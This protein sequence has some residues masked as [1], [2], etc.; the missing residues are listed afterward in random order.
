MNVSFILCSPFV[1]AYICFHRVSNVV[2]CGG[3]GDASGG[4]CGGAC[5]GGGAFAAYDDDVRGR[6]R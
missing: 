3:G 2:R 6:N 1:I 5:G 4:G